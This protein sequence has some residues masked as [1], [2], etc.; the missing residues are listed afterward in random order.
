MLDY[1]LTRSG[2][3]ASVE[4]EGELGEGLGL[5]LHEAGGEMGFL[6]GFFFM[7]SG[8]ENV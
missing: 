7:Y 6:Y 1:V 8:S 3:V 5:V 2:G 4:F